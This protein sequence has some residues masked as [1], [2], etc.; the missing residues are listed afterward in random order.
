MDLLTSVNIMIPI[1]CSE[2]DTQVILDLTQSSPGASSPPQGSCKNPLGFIILACIPT[3]QTG[4]LLRTPMWE[5]EFCYQ[6]TVSTR[7]CPPLV[8]ASKHLDSSYHL[9]SFLPS[10]IPKILSEIF[11]LNIQLPLSDWATLRQTRSFYGICFRISVP[12]PSGVSKLL[13]VKSTYT[14]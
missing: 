1:E 3:T 13:M 10:F 8:M 11:P 2:P 4:V 14:T 9:L 6:L 12:P 7:W 5:L